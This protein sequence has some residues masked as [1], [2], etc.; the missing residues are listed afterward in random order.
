MLLTACG[1]DSH[2]QE[3]AI[4]DRYYVENANYFMKLSMDRV[5]I[6]IDF[7]NNYEHYYD[8]T[9]IIDDCSLNGVKCSN[10][11]F[12]YVELHSQKLIPLLI[13][14]FIRARNIK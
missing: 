4:C 14:L 3:V 10:G 5:D 8:F 7:K 9:Q 1:S 2:N 12:P 13:T 6:G 11:R